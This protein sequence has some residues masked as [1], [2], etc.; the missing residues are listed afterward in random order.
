MNSDHLAK[1][2]ALGLVAVKAV[3][4]W[5]QMSDAHWTLYLLWVPLFWILYQGLIPILDAFTGKPYIKSM[6]N[7]REVKIYRNQPIQYCVE[8]GFSAVLLVAVLSMMFW[9]IP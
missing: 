3:L 4:S 8:L 1:G 9:L 7:H 2:I 6:H 5:E